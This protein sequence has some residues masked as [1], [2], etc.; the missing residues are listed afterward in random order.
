MSR[1]YSRLRR[2]SKAFTTRTQNICVRTGDKVH[3]SNYDKDDIN[4]DALANPNAT[5]SEKR[6]AIRN[7]FESNNKF[8]THLHEDYLTS[9][10]DI[11]R[12]HFLYNYYWDMCEDLP[13]W[14]QM[15]ID[16]IVQYENFVY[17]IRKREG[18]EKVYKGNPQRNWQVLD[19]SFNLSER[20]KVQSAVKDDR[21]VV[22]GM[23]TQT[24]TSL[25]MRRRSNLV[26]EQ[27]EKE[28]NTYRPLPITSKH[29]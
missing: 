17:D 2:S 9:S 22:L 8:N 7:A 24:S 18:K 10:E 20:I 12:P 4:L 19:N 26:I 21:S 29:I 14:R 3:I 6:T 16:M 15:K 11:Y 28:E 27:E 25:A 23:P 13:Q 5:D 1:R